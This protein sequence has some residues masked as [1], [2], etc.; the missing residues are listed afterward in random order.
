HHDMHR[1]GEWRVVGAG[2]LAGGLGMVR[3]RAVLSRVV[4]ARPDD[5]AL[6]IRSGGGDGATRVQD[7]QIARRGVRVRLV[8]V[9]LLAGG[10][11]AH[12]AVAVPAGRSVHHEAVGRADVRDAVAALGQVAF[13]G[14]RA[15]DGRALRV[16]GAVGA[17]PR[18][19]L[20]QIADAR[21]G[22]ARGRARPEGVGGAVVGSP[23][24]ALGDV[25]VPGGRAADGRA[26]RV[27][28]AADARPRAELG[29]I[30]DT[31]RGSARGRARPEGVGRAVVGSPVA[32]LGDV[33]VPGGRAADRR[34][35]RV[36][37][38]IGAAPRT[39][40]RYVA[41]P[42][43]G[44]ALGRG[45]LE[46][47]GR[48]V[49]REAVAALGEVAGARRRPADGRALRVGGADDAGAR[50]ELGQVADT[51][52]GAALR[53]AR[54]EGVG[55][56]IGAQAGAEL[57]DVAGTLRSAALGRARLEEIDRAVVG[58]PVTALGDVAVSGGGPADGRALRVGGA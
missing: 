3:R 43:R 33:T 29:Q 54:L 58:D 32:A 38:A 7:A 20:G 48:A 45:R 17:A 27:G 35:L 50:A 5:T 52:R 31:R 18:A 23:V 28:G 9:T 21:R 25:T 26:L 22:S 8:A 40:L 57:G 1:P 6:A 2:H 15:A 47:V 12:E 55:G 42:G 37:G 14:G 34:A 44:A 36:G 13:A 56:A 39:G 19:E 41:D 51:G 46:G 24:A 4:Q 10:R 49:V 30:A 53:R 11:R 16:G